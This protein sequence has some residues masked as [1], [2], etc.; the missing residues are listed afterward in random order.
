MNFT[1]SF[2]MNSCNILENNDSPTC[3]FANFTHRTSN[4]YI[5]NQ[6]AY[7]NVYNANMLEN[8]YYSNSLEPLNPSADMKVYSSDNSQGLAY[9]Y[10]LYNWTCIPRTKEECTLLLAERAANFKKSRITH[11][12]KNTFI[13]QNNNHKSN[14]SNDIVHLNSKNTTATTNDQSNIALVDE[15]NN[16]TLSTINMDKYNVSQKQYAKC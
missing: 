8:Q 16:S 12:H 9:R 14:M 15:H 11:T 4:D 13:N 10:D 3:S 1:N 5:N 2:G 7:N 6:Y